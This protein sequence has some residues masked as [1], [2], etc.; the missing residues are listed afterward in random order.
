MFKQY[1]Y[2]GGGGLQIPIMHCT[3]I[4]TAIIGGF[5]P[6]SGALVGFGSGY[7]DLR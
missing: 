5:D 4:G 2:E 7:S 6:D 1:M 3:L